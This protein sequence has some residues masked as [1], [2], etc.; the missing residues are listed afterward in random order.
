MRQRQ[1][2]NLRHRHCLRRILRH[3]DR[4]LRQRAIGLTDGHGD[5]VTTAIATGYDDRLPVTGMKSVTDN[6]LT[7]LIV[8]IM[9]LSRLRQVQSRTCG[10]A[11]PGAR[12]L[13]PYGRVPRSATRWPSA[14]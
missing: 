13:E 4:Q 2:W 6:R 1:T 5:V 7:Q 11:H 3:P 12:A 9:K 14:L 8:S 10:P